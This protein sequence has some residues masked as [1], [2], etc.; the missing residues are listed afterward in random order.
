MTHQELIDNPDYSLLSSLNHL[1][2]KELVL[3][4]AANNQGWAKI[5]NMYQVTGILAFIIGTF[6]AF[7]PFFVQR[8]LVHIEW[9]GIGMIFTFTGLVILHELL[10]A[11]AYRCLGVKHLSFGMI[12]RKFMFYVQADKEV[13]NYKQF[14]IVAL[15]PVIIVGILSIIGM[16]VFYNQPF[17]YFFLPIF[18]F[19]SVFCAGDFGLLCFF[20]NRNDQEILTFD[21]K[22]EGKTYF[23][24]KN[25]VVNS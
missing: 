3:N 23:Y 11:A 2:I 4:E 25:Q 13:L 21:V 10:H 9:L 18:S 20:Q 16:V 22:V 1:E 19:H 14:R 7:M 24:G 5:A 12:I 8:E 15:T 17:F 6:K